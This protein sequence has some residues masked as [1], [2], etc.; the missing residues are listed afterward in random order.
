VPKPF[1]PAENRGYRELYA[2]CRQLAEHWSAL[3][4]QLPPAARSPFERGAR[5]GRQT[6]EE[7]EPLTANYGLHGGPA[8]QGVGKSVAGARSAVRDRFLETDRAARW[9]L[10]E[11]QYTT[12]L[13]GFLRAVAESRDDDRLVEF[14]GKAERRFRRLEGE[15]RKAVVE[16]GADPD[17]A[18][19]P[20]DPS[21]VGRAAQ[22]VTYAVGSVG[23]WFDRMA[24]RRR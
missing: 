1:H 16:L 2:F 18:V 13:L 6:L 20:L 4:E 14:C 10:T 8:A 19:E 21:P 12:T 23:E 24:A 17:L 11:L 22:S 5:L 9:A 3:V 7:L 15:A